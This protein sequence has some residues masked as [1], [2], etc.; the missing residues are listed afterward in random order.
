MSQFDNNSSTTPGSSSGAYYQIRECPDFAPLEAPRSPLS[1]IVGNGK[2]HGNL[3]QDP[4]HFS[5]TLVAPDEEELVN[6]YQ[7]DRGMDVDEEYKSSIV[8]DLPYS[9]KGTAHSLASSRYSNRS[10]ASIHGDHQIH[11]DAPQ[12]PAQ[13]DSFFDDNDSDKSDESEE[14]DDSHIVSERYDT[15][16]LPSRSATVGP[17]RVDRK[18]GKASQGKRGQF[19]GLRGGST[20]QKDTLASHQV[21]GAF[22]AH[23]ASSDSGY[24]SKT[25]SMQSFGIEILHFP[26]PAS[27]LRNNLSRQSDGQEWTSQNTVLHSIS[28]PENH[29]GMLGFNFNCCGSSRLQDLAL[30]AANMSSEEVYGLLCNYMQCEG[31]RLYDNAGNT[32][33]HK[34]AIT[35]ASW[36]YFEAAFKARIDPCHRNAYE[37]TFAHVL[38]VSAFRDNLMDCLSFIRGLG[39]DFGSRDASGRTVLHCLYDQPISPQTA[40]EILKLIETP[41]RHLSLR[42][43]SGRSPCEVFKQTF[44]RQAYTNPRW[45]VT[46]LQLQNFGIFEEIVNDGVLRL[47]DEGIDWQ[48]VTNYPEE[49]RATLQNQ[50]KEV[51]DNARNGIAVEAVDGSNAF[52][53][54]A[55]LMTADDTVTD[56]CSLEK[57]ISVGIDT[58]DYDNR[59]RTPLEAIITQ[60]KDFENELTKSEKVSLLIDKG[61]ASV[62]SRNRLGHTPLYSAAIRGLD[63]TVEV[64]LQRGSHVNI[65]ANNNTSL[66]DAVKGAWDRALMEYLESR[67]NSKY[68]EVQCSRIEACKVLLERYGAVS[69]PLPAQSM[70]YQPMGYPIYRRPHP[71]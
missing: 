33:L 55:G 2:G 49:L 56:L 17:L 7:S 65:R 67:L 10:Q 29:Q 38:N 47:G 71:E 42:D 14:M 4:S 3:Q 35:G 70:G 20:L 28:C 32:F 8:Q 64:L 62:H 26:R 36:P 60:P 48:R 46:G 63:R 68:H 11:Y 61:R 45:S 13:D 9:D 34:L 24:A 37:Q 19:R 58:N 12:I 21:A 16:A 52:H 69:D 66:L 39:I 54:Q 31:I 22:V 59:G 30:C 50:Y 51:I 6:V 27:N 23:R 1:D 5:I 41:G 15:P 53:A 25:D 18:V 44:Q 57:F 40:R 43:V